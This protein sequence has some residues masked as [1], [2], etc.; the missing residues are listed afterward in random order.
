MRFLRTI[1]LDAS[2]AEVYDQVAQ[3]GEWAVPGSFSFLDDTILHFHSHWR[4]A[5][6]ARGINFDCFAWKKPADRQRFK[7]S[8][9]EPLLFAVYSDA[10]LGGKVVKR[11]KRN[12]EVG[13]RI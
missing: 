10:I 1:R 13:V 9:G 8:L 11:R 3:P 2:D 4:T 12:D 5:I 7:T 6:Q